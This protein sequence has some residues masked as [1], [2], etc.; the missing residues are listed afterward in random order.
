M[1][2]AAGPVSTGDPATRP[3]GTPRAVVVASCVRVVGPPDGHAAQHAPSRHPRVARPPGAMPCAGAVS[4]RRTGRDRPAGRLV[5]GH[6]TAPFS[7][8]AGPPGWPRAWQLSRSMAA[9]PW[10]CSLHPDGVVRAAGRL[11]QLD[12][13]RR[14]AIGSL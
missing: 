9:A 6:G 3:P 2:V 7:R 5:D 13:A 12:S 14:A 10:H 8:L 11:M 4:A 1:L